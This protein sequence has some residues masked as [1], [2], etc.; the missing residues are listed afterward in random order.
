MFLPAIIKNKLNIFN[1]VNFTRLWKYIY[2]YKLQRKKYNYFESRF[3]VH[4]KNL[5]HITR[6]NK[7]RHLVYI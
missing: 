6:N 3:L 4:V 2:I 1:Q 5:K 7:K